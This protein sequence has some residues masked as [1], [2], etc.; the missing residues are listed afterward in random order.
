MGR[1][2]CAVAI[3]SMVMTGVAG[4][5]PTK[6]EC[7]DAHSRGQDA[8]DQARLTQARKLFLTC[9]Q[10]S[11]PQLVIND[12]ARWADDL[13]RLQPT[14]TFAARDSRGADLPETAV[15]IDGLLVTTRLDDGRPRDIDPGRHVVRFIHQGRNQTLT[16]VVGAGERGRNVVAIFPNLGDSQP[17]AHSAP[18]TGAPRSEDRATRP[19]GAVA[20]LI[21]G[22]AL[23]VGGVT[24]GAFEISRVPNECSFID[25]QC[26]ATP[27][28]PVFDQAKRA[29]QLANVGWAIAGVGLA[30]GVGGAI[31]YYVGAD[32]PKRERMAIAPWLSP[33]VGGLT[34]SGSM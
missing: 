2:L 25:R 6:E 1:I 32:R 3:G 13:V 27:G 33:S 16:V 21:G 7:I 24:F 14:V 34:V 18:T 29:V 8:R 23:A 10:S 4:A 15:Y 30:A 22:A 19:I 17:G 28:D 26:A 5:E 9:A 31:W 11:C 20:L 12:C